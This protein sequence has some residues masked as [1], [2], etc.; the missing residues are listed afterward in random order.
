[1]NGIAVWRDAAADGPTNMAADE[2]LAAA[3]VSRGGL[4]IRLYRWETTTVSLGAFQP[5]AAAQA[6][7]AIAGIP[8][9]RR[10][11]G[12]GAIVHGSDFTYAAA[13]PKQ[14]PWG[15]SAQPLY[16]ALHGAMVE[17]LRAWG[18]ETRLSDPDPMAEGEF[19]C[20]DRRA[21]G[22]LVA[23]R[24]EAGAEPRGIKLMGSA[25]RRLADAVLQHGSLLLAENPAVGSAAR[26][27]PL[28]ALSTATMSG[29]D[30]WPTF[31]NDWLERIG[32]ALGQRIE[33]QPGSFLESCPRG[34]AAGRERFAAPRWTNRR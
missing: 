33:H 2:C 19:F 31:V 9:V 11:S 14:H 21:G 8:L 26:H 13:I 23:D 16:D 24:P 22:D 10:P 1:M 32:Q 27:R 7:A 17:T 30:G 28:A 15:A 34:L 5:I 6:C 25:Q 4:V 29:A 18:V 12:G 20:F 3:A